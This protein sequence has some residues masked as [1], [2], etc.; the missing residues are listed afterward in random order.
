MHTISTKDVIVLPDRQRKTID[1][2]SLA[3]LIKSIRAIGLIQPIVLRNED[4]TL[5]A[6]QRRL[7][8]FER[9]GWEEIPF[10]RMADLTPLEQKVVEF[11]E[12]HKREAL[13]YAEEAQAILEIHQLL[14]VT[15]TPDGLVENSEHRL[16]DTADLLKVS[17]S[18][19][20]QDVRLA[21][22]LSEGGVLADKVLAHESRRGAL[23]TFQREREL[24][25][26]RELAKRRGEKV[27]E[28]TEGSSEI[29]DY[30]SG[31][32]YH[33][34]CVDVL[35]TME[36][37]S[38]DL[39]VTDPPWGV[40]LSVSTTW[41]KQWTDRYDDSPVASLDLMEVVF[42][43][44]YKVLKPAG[45]LYMFAPLDLPTW[46]KWHDILVKSSFAVRVRP[47]IWAKSTPGITE[48]Y[49]SFIPSYEGIIFASKLEDGKS[50]LFQRPIM[51]C[52]TEAR[53]STH[54]HPNEKPERILDAMIQSSSEMTEVVLD[55]FCGGGSVLARAIMNG[56]RY[57]GIEK[58]PQYANT[59]LER[60]NVMEA[61]SERFRQALRDTEYLAPKDDPSANAAFWEA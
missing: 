58:D 4:N 24:A 23:V 35:Q 7:L 3:E 14:S 2:T 57:I 22:A 10:R 20:Q 28:V 53:Q 49:T 61:T 37:N 45:H 46:T 51:D 55:P 54:Y 43:L 59:C 30:R 11:D 34:D 41:S 60:I 50:R 39:I 17:V 44:L 18:K 21:Q 56:R 5:L 32:V 52:W 38:I 48:V 36:E 47:L 31:R 8:A 15:S 6:G 33:D 1:E 25:I 40:D 13:T 12:N 19:V 29:V 42:P 9:I 27:P 26:I 16:Q